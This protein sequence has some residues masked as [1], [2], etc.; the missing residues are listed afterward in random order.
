MYKEGCEAD[1]WT[2]NLLPYFH[3][4]NMIVRATFTVKKGDATY[5][6]PHTRNIVSYLCPGGHDFSVF[7]FLW[8]NMMTTKTI[9]P[10]D[11]THSR[12]HVMIKRIN[13]PPPHL[14]TTRMSFGV[15]I[16]E[17][18]A[19]TTTCVASATATAIAAM[20]QGTYHPP[21]MQLR[22]TSVIGA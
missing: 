2:K 4:I 18:L 7:D 21:S 15:H 14:R 20:G 10:K 8:N 13:D 6:I 9:F 22:S 12:L 19:A 16:P 1:D 3:Y 5:L 11:H 17:T